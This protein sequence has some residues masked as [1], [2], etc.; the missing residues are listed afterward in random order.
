[1]EPAGDTFLE[2]TILWLAQTILANLLLDKLDEWLRRVGLADDTEKLKSQIEEADALVAS[3][4]GRAA[5]NRLLARSLAHLKELLYDSDDLV[6]ELDYCRL[7]HQVEGGMCI[8]RKSGDKASHHGINFD[9]HFL[10]AQFRLPVL[11]TSK[12]QMEMQQSKLMDRE[13]T[14]T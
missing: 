9:S 7:Q 10:L 13:T 14:L 2:S 5:G 6:D 3:V 8:Q 1:M 11:M 4:K 12:A